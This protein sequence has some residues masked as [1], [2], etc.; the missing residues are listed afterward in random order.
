MIL[1]GLADASIMTS[2]TSLAANQFSW[3]GTNT[4]SNIDVKYSERGKCAGITS[5]ELLALPCDG[6]HHFMCEAPTKQ[7]TTE[8]PSSK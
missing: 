6:K 7:E 8:P 4:V 2:L 5:L 1:A 3:D